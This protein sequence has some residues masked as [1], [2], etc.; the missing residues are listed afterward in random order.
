MVAKH[1]NRVVGFAFAFG[2]VHSLEKYGSGLLSAKG[3]PRQ[4]IR[5]I[6]L[7]KMRELMSNERCVCF[8]HTVILKS[9]EGYGLESY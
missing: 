2:Y 3:E 6:C 9:Y 7:E 4:A 5:T 8:N 1:E